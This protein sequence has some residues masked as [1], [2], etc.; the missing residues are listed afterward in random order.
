MCRLDQ[1][2]RDGFISMATSLDFA[3]SSTNDKTGD[4]PKDGMTE[5]TSLVPNGKGV[6]QA[7]YAESS[8]T[9]TSYGTGEVVVVGWLLNVPATCVC[10]SGTDLLRRFYVLP[11]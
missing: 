11:R 5:T 7:T 8:K 6:F 4:I 10:I 3:R 1:A 2:D 9:D